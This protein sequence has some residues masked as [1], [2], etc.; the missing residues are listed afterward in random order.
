M[1]SN[2]D[3]R[4]GSSSAGENS[5]GEAGQAKRAKGAIWHRAYRPGLG[6]PPACI[7]VPKVLNVTASVQSGPQRGAVGKLKRDL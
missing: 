4:N 5:A 2:F 1:A 6:R 7:R 3:C